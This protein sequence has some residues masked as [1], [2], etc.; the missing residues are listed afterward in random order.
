MFHHKTVLLEETVQALNLEALTHTDVI[1]FDGT[2]GGGGHSNAILNK[3]KNVKLIGIDRDKDAILAAKNRLKEFDDRFQVVQGNFKDIKDI[4]TS[5]N[6]SSINGMILDLG[7]S[8]YQLDTADRGFSYQQDHK[9]DMRMDTDAD[10]SAFEIVN[11][12][13][14]NRLFSIIRD[15]GEERW[16]KRIAEFIVEK[17]TQKPIET[18]FELVS[19]IKSA[20]PLGARKDGP[21]PAKRTFQA[22]RIEVNGEL[23]ILENTIKSICEL[24]TTGGRLAI[25]TF[26]SLEDRIVKK[27]FQKLEKTCTCPPDFPVCVCGNE[28]IIKIVN[29]KPIIPSKKELE[30][31]SRARSAK[32]RILEK[33]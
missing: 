24:L 15:Y 17:R 12:Y 11:T 6:I 27:T 31:N 8:S 2:L 16:A 19:I 13:D 21:H 14:V 25:I 33:L 29:K 4:C 32:L 5:L 7:V 3:Y 18:T 9:L 20:I 10:I 28:P 30:Q 22:I 26:H 23:E 1:C